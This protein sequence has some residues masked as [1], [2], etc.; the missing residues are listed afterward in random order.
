MNIW[1]SKKKK[2]LRSIA[3]MPQLKRQK[4]KICSEMK[5]TFVP[6][7]SNLISERPDNLE[8]VIKAEWVG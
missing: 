2:I 3:V 8:N 7:L 4:Q 5:D 1:F 6:M